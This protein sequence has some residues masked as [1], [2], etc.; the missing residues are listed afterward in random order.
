MKK[1]GLIAKKTAALLLVATLVAGSLSGCEYDSVDDYLEALGMKDQ[2]DD[3]EGSI[4][5]PIEGTEVSPSESTASDSE[6]QLP[7]DL[8]S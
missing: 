3:S 7:T 5:E 6:L 1:L 2:P 4:L 8:I